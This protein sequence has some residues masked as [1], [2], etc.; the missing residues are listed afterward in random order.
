MK[1]TEIISFP[2]PHRK[3]SP[4]RI[5]TNHL[6]YVTKWRSLSKYPSFFSVFALLTFMFPHH[7]AT[8]DK[9]D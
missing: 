7:S 6:V 8:A 5:L 2:Q 9:Q 4:A 1:N 3:P